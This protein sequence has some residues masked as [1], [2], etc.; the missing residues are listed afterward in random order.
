MTGEGAGGAGAGGDG[1]ER[2]LEAWERGLGRAAAAVPYALLLVS[3]VLALVEPGRSAA[4]RIGTLALAAFTA[5][6]ML[7]LVTLHPAWA[8]RRGVMAVYCAGLIALIAAL[9]LRSPWFSFFAF[10]GYLHA[11]ALLTGRWRLVGVAVTALVSSTWVLHAFGAVTVAAV[12][13]WLGVAAVIVALVALFSRH[14]DVTAEQSRQRKEM[15]ADLAEANRRLEAALEENA[16]LH[17]QLMAQAREAGALDERQRMARE[18]HDTIA[19]GLAGVITQIQAAEQAGGRDEVRRRH[20]DNATRLA[21]ESLD[22]A[23]RSVR[24]IRPEPLEAARLPDAIAEVARRWSSLHGVA[25]EVATTGDVR[26][27]HPEVEVT[28]L[29]TAQEALANVA[30][31]ARATR[32]GLTL[33]YMEDLVTLDV[34]DD[35]AGFDPTAVAAARP[36][37]GYGLRAMRQRVLRLAG[38]LEIESEPG[39]GT[40]VWAGLPAVPQEEPDA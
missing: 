3:T 32:V 4:D 24:A 6:W 10:T 16:G 27:M 33:S 37:G 30:K 17:A 31:H 15:I 20:L 1:A 23:R 36:D 29:R 38:K 13:A 19:Q 18:I 40:A 12:G 22:E 34:R 14:G 5:A 28:L 9:L 35:G 21:R 39:G 11:W 25:A 2:R 26:P 8:T 7:W